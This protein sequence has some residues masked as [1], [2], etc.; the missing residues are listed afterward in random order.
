MNLERFDNHKLIKVTFS[1]GQELTGMH[2]VI[3]TNMT[4]KKVPIYCL[5]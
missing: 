4:M 1:D 5:F 2:M 3:P